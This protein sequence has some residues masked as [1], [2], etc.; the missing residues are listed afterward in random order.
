[1]FD[2]LY[3]LNEAQICKMAASIPASFCLFFRINRQKAHKQAQ[4]EHLL[5]YKM[6]FRSNSDCHLLRIVKIKL[7]RF[8]KVL[9]INDML[10]L[11][12]H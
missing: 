4:I 12:I 10:R 7:F 8:C 11:N 3:H 2:L 6:R 5:G 1:M 9:I